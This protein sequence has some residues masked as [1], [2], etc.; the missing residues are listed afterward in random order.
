MRIDETDDHV[1][2]ERRAG[3][4]SPCGCGAIIVGRG[5]KDAMNISVIVD[6]PPQVEERLRAESGDLSSAVR[7][8]FAINLFRRGILSHHELGQVLGLDRFET[9]A[10]LKRNEVTEYSLTHE[11]IDADVNSL[12]EF[13][14][15]ARP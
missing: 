4:E 7:E 15:L 8:S 5:A 6:L 11:D 3:G 13:L 14:G 2:P 1:E 9:D 10:L 12:K